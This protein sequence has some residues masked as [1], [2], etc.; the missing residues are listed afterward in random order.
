MDFHTL[1]KK[2]DIKFTGILHVGAHVCEEIYRYEDYLTRDKILWVEA[3]PEKVNLVKN[4]YPGILIEQAVISDKEEPVKFNITNNAQSSS[5][6]NLGLH[7]TYYPHIEYVDSF[8]TVSTTIKNI[9]DK[10][11]ELNINFLNLD[12]QGVELK[13][14][15]GMGDYLKNIDYLITEVNDD[16]VYEGCCLVSELDEYLKSYDLYRVV[17]EMT[18]HHWGDSFY[19]KKKSNN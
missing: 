3:I 1:V 12:L 4:T 6:L 15:V 16:Y 11:P 5:I 18:E 8:Q 14:L 9:L 13:A 2:Y 19:I 10:Y 17:T 7:K